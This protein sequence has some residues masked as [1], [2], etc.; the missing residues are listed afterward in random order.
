MDAHRCVATDAGVKCRAG[1]IQLSTKSK[2]Y[3]KVGRGVREESY[4]CVE[5]RVY[6]LQDEPDYRVGSVTT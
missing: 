1:V 5:K 6:M 3:T 4:R 2:D